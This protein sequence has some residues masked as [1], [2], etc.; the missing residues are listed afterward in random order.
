[1][2]ILLFIYIPV[3][4]I[5]IMAMIFDAFIICSIIIAIKSIK[6]QLSKT[7]KT[8]FASVLQSFSRPERI[9]EEEVSISK[10]KKVCL[11]CKSG[12]KKFNVYIC[13]C[14][15]FY[16]KNCAR[17]LVNIENAC[18]VCNTPFDDSKPSK[19]FKKEEEIEEIEITE[20]IDKKW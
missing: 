16:C 9:T 1:V 8:E 13:D 18:W 5:F 20:R 15:T 12:V 19:P 7:E 3:L 11:V 6:N 17:A 2:F 10:E 14:D 4:D